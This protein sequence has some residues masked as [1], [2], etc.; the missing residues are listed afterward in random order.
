VIAEALLF[1]ASGQ[2]R[3][4]ASIGG[5]IMQRTRC[6]YFRDETDGRCNKRHPGSGC[7]ALHGLNR[8]H[9]APAVRRSTALI[10][11]TRFSDG[12]SPVWRPTRPILRLRL[13]L[14]TRS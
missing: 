11:I 5:N 12:L 13:Q 14:W 6:A 2:L 4:M 3:N 1:S 10:A 7:A 9:A 8:N